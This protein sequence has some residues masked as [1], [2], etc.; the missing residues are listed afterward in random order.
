M[1]VEEWLDGRSG[2][3][4]RA[5]ALAAGFTA[6]ALTAA[7][8]R[9][10][11]RLAR[12][13]W[14]Y[15][16]TCTSPLLTAAQLGARLTCLSAARNHG[17][18]LIDDGRTHLSVRRNAA[19]RSAPGLRFHW[20]DPVVPPDRFELVEPV[21][22][23]LGHV[24]DCQPFESAVVV[25]DSAIRTAAVTYA[26]LARW[27]RRST[28]FRRLVAAT[29]ELSD[30]GI[31]TLPRVR[32]SRRGIDMRQQVVIDGHPVDGLIGDRL[33]IQIDGY[34]PH[35]DPQRRRRDLA[36]DARLTLL[37]YTVLRFDYYQVMY[38]WGSVE[39]TILSAMAQGLHLL[40]ALTSR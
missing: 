39:R 25:F 15:T 35:S 32:L 19:V 2:I 14:L 10:R 37:G 33:V 1:D 40:P 18:W 16:R 26:Q 9:G 7:I 31:E 4:H 12:R 30:S 36:Q 27:Q 20:G 29:G 24:A 28:A 22:N 5:D 17:L 21:E 3:A 13:Q 34:G 11:L 38:D 23:V 6:Y 8:R